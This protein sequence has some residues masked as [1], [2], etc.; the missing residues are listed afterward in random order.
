MPCVGKSEGQTKRV[1]DKKKGGCYGSNLI[2]RDPA[3]N[4]KSCVL[5]FM[6][7]TKQ[8]ITSSTDMSREF[9]L[10]TAQRSRALQKWF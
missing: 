9:T 8:D 1:E 5:K 6:P 2:C 3:V 7:T 10:W 4:L